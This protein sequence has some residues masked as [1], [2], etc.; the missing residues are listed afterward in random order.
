MVG[1][2]V[3][4]T[5]RVQLAILALVSLTALPVLAKHQAVHRA[6][7]NQQGGHQASQAPEDAESQEQETSESAAPEQAEGD[8]EQADSSSKEES[9]TS[10][11]SESN[12][13]NS[14]SKLPLSKDD[15]AKL[16]VGLGA[17]SVLGQIAL[18]VLVIC[19]LQGGGVLSGIVICAFVY[20]L[21]RLFRGGKKPAIG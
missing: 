7:T 5:M 2:N 9:T 3:V 13:S 10:R 18:I 1:E 21:G 12:E 8:A 16:G 6:A 19:F 14:S 17:I 11:S 20:H 15:L 4:K